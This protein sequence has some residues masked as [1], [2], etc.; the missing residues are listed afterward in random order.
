MTS[1]RVGVAALCLWIL[2]AV[3]IAAAAEQSVASLTRRSKPLPAGGKP[4]R[5]YTDADLQRSRGR[6]T[7]SK[8]PERPADSGAPATAT[9]ADS[10]D[11][12]YY[13][14]FQRQLSWLERTRRTY[15]EA[16]RRYADATGG[17]SLG[18][19]VPSA[20]SGGTGGAVTTST[21]TGSL[22]ADLWAVAEIQRERLERAR[23]VMETALQSLAD[24]REEARRQG[25][26]P[27]VYRRAAQDWRKE[28]PDAPSPP[29]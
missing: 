3:A 27:G 16:E 24:L 25:V 14:E 15:V 8:V 29:P 26:P 2:A 1:R 17:Y 4:A 19:P 20:R 23:A 21:T 12:Y 28:H 18:W 6:L 9:S 13:D 10:R 7:Q 11:D 5:V 22:P